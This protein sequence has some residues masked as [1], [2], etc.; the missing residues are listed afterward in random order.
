VSTVLE[1]LQ[2][3]DLNLSGING[4]VGAIAGRNQLER[5]LEL[6]DEGKNLD[7]ECDGDE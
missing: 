7:D 1:L 4:M 3:A 5:V 2:C 6:I